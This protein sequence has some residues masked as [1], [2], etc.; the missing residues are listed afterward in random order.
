LQFEDRPDQNKIATGKQLMYD[1]LTI[2][3]PE[4]ETSEIITITP[5]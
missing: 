4:Q 5:R 1:G 2:E 3:L